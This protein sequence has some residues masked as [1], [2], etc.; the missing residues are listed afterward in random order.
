MNHHCKNLYLKFYKLVDT[1]N[2]PDLDLNVFNYN[3]FPY[4]PFGGCNLRNSLDVLQNFY[5]SINI[6]MVYV[7]LCNLK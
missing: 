1:F 6:N 5:L 2:L 4:Y 3:L 7:A